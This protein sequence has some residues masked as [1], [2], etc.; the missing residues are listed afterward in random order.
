MS[1]THEYSNGE[2]TI[3][4]QPDICMHSGNC[5]KNLATVFKPKERPWIQPEN[6]STQEIMS[7]IDKCPSGALSYRKNER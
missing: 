5:V 1:D 4:W 3:V 7:A 2:I 6:A